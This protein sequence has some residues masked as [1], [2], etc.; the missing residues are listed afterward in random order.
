[1]VHTGSS[2]GRLRGTLLPAAAFFPTV[3]TSSVCVLPNLALLNLLLNLL[4]TQFTQITRH[5]MLFSP[6]AVSGSSCGRP[7]RAGCSKHA[8]VPPLLL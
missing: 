6:Q 3:F 4:Q 1:M 8:R 5:H 7:H 2:L